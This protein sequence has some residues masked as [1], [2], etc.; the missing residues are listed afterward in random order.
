MD[1]EIVK[2][3]EEA[4]DKRHLL[5]KLAPPPLKNIFL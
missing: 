2:E 3:I 4:R 1:P 5:K